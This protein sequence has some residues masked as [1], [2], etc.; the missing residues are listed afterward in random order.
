KKYNSTHAKHREELKTCVNEAFLER[1]YNNLEVIK[2]SLF[3]IILLAKGSMG[4][5]KKEK[6][7]DNMQNKNKVANKVKY[8]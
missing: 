3:D 1:Q 2:S 4:E 5:H 6:N 8:V 7:K